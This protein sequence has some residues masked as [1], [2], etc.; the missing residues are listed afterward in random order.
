MVEYSQS[1]LF[2][3][4]LGNFSG[5]SVFKLVG[6]LLGTSLGVFGLIALFIVFMVARG[7]CGCMSGFFRCIALCFSCK[8]KSAEN[9]LLWK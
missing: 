1:K 9:H 4:F 7:L 3:L 2:Q 5:F 6:G 8:K